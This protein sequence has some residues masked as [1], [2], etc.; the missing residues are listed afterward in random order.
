M[1]RMRNPTA[2]NQ[3]I[4]RELQKKIAAEI[5]AAYTAGLEPMRQLGEMDPADVT[6]QD[7]VDALR[8]LRQS[9]RLIA[10]LQ[11]DLMGAVVLSGGTVNY[12]SDEATGAHISASTLT[13]RLPRTPAALIGKDLAWDPS[14]EYGW[15]ALE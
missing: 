11:L 9:R 13:R 10:K 6:W 4:G 2:A 3:H 15:R 7:A 14:S 5:I 1:G 12:L 8:A